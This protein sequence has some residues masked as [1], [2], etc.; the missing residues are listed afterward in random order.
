MSPASRAFGCPRKLSK[1]F[2]SN[3]SRY[4]LRHLQGANNLPFDRAYAQEMMAVCLGGTARRW[5]SGLFSPITL[6]TSLLLRAAEFPNALGG[7]APKE[8]SHP[9]AQGRHP[10]PKG[11]GWFPRS[12]PRRIHGLQSN[13]RVVL[14]AFAGTV[15]HQLEAAPRAAV[16]RS[17]SE[18]RRRPDGRWAQRAFQ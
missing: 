12:A 6:L 16:P 11:E 10:F 1:R 15:R 8:V 7:D 14:G 13:L 4:Y 18:S 5:V 2:W 17:R 9:S 3:A